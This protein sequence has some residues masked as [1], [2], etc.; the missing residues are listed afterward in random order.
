VANTSE[1]YQANR[2]QIE[3]FTTMLRRARGA[4][5]ERIVRIPIVVH[6]LHHGNTDNI[7]DAQI[8]SQIDVLNHDYRRLNADVTR[9]PPPFGPL[10]A[11]SM[12]E[13]GLAVKDPRG[14][15]TGGITRT[16]T[17]LAVFQ[18]DS[19]EPEQQILELEAKI[20]AAGSGVAAWPRDRY[21]NIWVC[22]MN[23]NPL[24]YAQFPGGPSETDGVV[25]DVK[26]FGVGGSAE[27]PFD[28]G[29]TGRT[30]SVTG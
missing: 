12:I 27:P 9:V 3:A 26:C 24:G 7:S 8:R 29:R 16:H 30:K 4:R 17:P 19:A 23:Q 1:T 13:F 15:A 5:R 28:R 22:H 18:P 11:D 6:V 14:Y 25:V 2:R 21:L 20:K 10:A